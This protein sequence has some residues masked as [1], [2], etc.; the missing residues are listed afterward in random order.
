MGSISSF[1]SVRKVFC[2]LDFEAGFSLVPNAGSN[3][4]WCE[5]TDVVP[6]F[7]GVG[8]SLLQKNFLCPLMRS[9][10]CVAKFLRSFIT[11]VLRDV[12]NV[13][14]HVCV[15]LLLEDH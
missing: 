2:V 6:S 14:L 15:V 1:I 10:I 9:L 12:E 7:R 4:E 5:I 8:G 11:Y 13:P 3:L